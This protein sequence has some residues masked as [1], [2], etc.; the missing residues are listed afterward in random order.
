MS[1][2]AHRPSS[3][4]CSA[5]PALE[6][7]DAGVRQNARCT[8]QGDRRATAQL[9]WCAALATG[10]TGP[11]RPALISAAVACSLACL[12]AV[13]GLLLAEWRAWPA[14]RALCKA[15]A[16]AAFVALALSLHALD[17]SLGRWMLL[18][19]GL[20]WLGDVCLL[21]GSSVFFLAG[22]GS[23]L[24]AHLAFGA[25]FATGPLDG[26]ALLVGLLLMGGV[27]ALALRWLW[28]HLRGAYR[29]AVA[30][31]VL[32]IMAMCALAGARASALGAWPV[33]LGAL[34]FAAS[35]L[36]VA[37]ER[38]ISASGWNKAWGLPLYYAAQLVLTWSILR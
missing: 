10:Q 2:E 9:G 34:A 7:R 24:L 4:G 28:P 17:S 12:L 5:T 19:G 14:T 13:A 27:G 38:F 36:A 26:R 30:S 29:T 18:A 31:Y 37:R 35:D 21:S 33:A 16:S 6:G 11:R 15:S 23:F 25:A 22:L 32:A 20:S 8:R 1:S 3:I